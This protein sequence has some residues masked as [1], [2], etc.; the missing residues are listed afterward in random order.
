MSRR[1]Q[2]GH[3]GEQEE[4]RHCP[5]C[6]ELMQYRLGGYECSACGTQTPRPG[7]ETQ[8]ADHE[9]ATAPANHI[10]I[11]V[12]TVL[13][14]ESRICYWVFILRFVAILLLLVMGMF[15]IIYTARWPGMLPSD[16]EGRKLFFIVVIFLIGSFIKASIDSVWLAR[17]F[18]QTLACEADG[19]TTAFWLFG[20][21]AWG[22]AMLVLG[23]GLTA[24]G[25]STI[26]WDNWPSDIW[27]EAVIG[28]SLFEAVFSL[29]AA[30]LIYRAMNLGL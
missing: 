21:M 5:Q 3:S 26:F 2:A 27:R 17:G 25:M 30:S 18:R 24:S 6:G 4:P 9:T 20:C 14:L 23:I 1:L 22:T 13:S 7:E 8:A 28:I 10:R 12:P 16:L 11:V 29:W 19:L 15:F